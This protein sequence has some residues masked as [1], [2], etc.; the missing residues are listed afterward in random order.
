MVM[1]LLSAAMLM[2]ES[3]AADVRREGAA[4]ALSGELKQR[5]SSMTAFL[6]RS[7]RPR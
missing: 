3:C 5:T 6:A 4:C 7:T 1:P 2:I